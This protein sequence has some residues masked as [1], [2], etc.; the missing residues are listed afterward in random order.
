MRCLDS[1]LAQ[2]VFTNTASEIQRAGCERKHKP[3]A[4]VRRFVGVEYS[5]EL[6]ASA[7][8]RIKAGMVRK[9]A[10]QNQST[11]IAPQRGSR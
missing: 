3:P 2:A 6:A 4:R 10:S 5:P 7:A 9:G 8:E 11:A 1:T